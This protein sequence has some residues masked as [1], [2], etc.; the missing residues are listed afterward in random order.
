[1]RRTVLAMAAAVL[2][3]SCTQR[4]VAIPAVG[5]ISSPSNP[6]TAA[7]NISITIPQAPQT[8]SSAR[9]AAYISTASNSIVLTPQGQ[10]PIVMPLTTTTPGCRTL[11]GA[12]I[13]TFRISLPTGAYTMRV[14]LFATVDGTGVPLAVVST[15]TTI[16]ANTTNNIDFT[17][18]AVVASIAVSLAPDGNFT[19]GTAATKTIVVAAFD[20]GGGTIIVGSDAL[21][22]SSG[23]PVTIQLG[24][25]DSS[26][27]TSIAPTVA[28]ST[29]STLSYN[30]GTPNATTVL[31]V[32]G[33]ATNAAVASARTAFA[34]VGAGGCGTASTTDQRRKASASCNLPSHFL[35]SPLDCA[36]QPCASPY[37]L[38]VY[39]PHRINTVM[40]HHLSGMPPYASAVYAD[41]DHVIV[42]FNG[43]Y[44]DGLPVESQ[45]CV[46]GT[47]RLN[48]LSYSSPVDDSLDLVRQGFVCDIGYASYD[49]HPGYDYL[50]KLNT[51]VYPAGTGTV[52]DNGDQSVGPE[53][54]R[55]I[56]TSRRVPTTC[57]DW[58]LVGIDHKNGYVSQY[59]HLS[60]IFV[61]PGTQIT[62]DWIDQRRPIG[63][64]GQMA[65]PESQS[66][67]GPHLHFE[68]LAH[69]PSFGTEPGNYDPSHW[70]FV[71]PYGWTGGKG[72]KYSEKG[73]PIYSAS[74]GIPPMQLWK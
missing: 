38:G 52:V 40:D 22:D 25:T 70:A 53:S 13:C 46:K 60:K 71:D 10:P 34:V 54:R 21:V 67:V 23:S 63:M 58:G 16:V 31:A 36:D 42:A 30:G 26:G 4:N 19:A 43:E 33:S 61:G 51:P 44:A 56:R 9:R 3:C 20:A 35:S 1:M 39:T 50:A 37:P 6:T 62:Q 74:L 57:A 2:V 18:N 29:P 11:N 45:I 27:T 55:C 5:S 69:I 32:A 47:I 73:D 8:S 65:P 28:G 48:T 14:A 66:S 17:L 72:L 49:G 59:E 12:R 15:P 64:S 41:L 24:D 7:S 68:V